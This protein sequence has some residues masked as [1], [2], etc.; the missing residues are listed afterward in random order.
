MIVYLH[1]LTGLRR[2]S[3][4]V[5]LIWAGVILVSVFFVPETFHPILLSRKA[6]T[7]RKSTNNNE[8]H[9]ASEVARASKTLSQA[10]LTSLCVPFQLLFLDPMVLALSTYTSLLQGILYLFFGAFPLVFGTNHGFNLWQI[11]LTFLGLLFGNLIA[12][13]F[14]PSWHKNWMWLIR[15][16]KEKHGADYK[17]EPEL[18]LPP[19]MV[20]SVL[21]T[22][23]LFWFAW[24]TYPSVHWIVPI[25]A[26]VVFSTGYV[27]FFLI[28]VSRTC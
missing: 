9:S 15:K 21:V 12:C 16:M 28:T 6:A 18:R 20:G 23:A 7:L 4:Y 26:T 24:T 2:W 13:F 3:F 17:P 19:A 22:V 5:L 11:G 8:Y 25:I 10:L 14:N 1:L 27:A